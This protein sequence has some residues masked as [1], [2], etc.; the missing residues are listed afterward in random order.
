[1]RSS[2]KT[3]LSS[4]KHSPAHST[5]KCYNSTFFSNTMKGNTKFPETYLNPL[6]CPIHL[7]HMPKV[8]AP[9]PAPA[10]LSSDSLSVSLFSFQR[11]PLSS[12]VCTSV[13]LSPFP[14]SQDLLNY[15]LT[16]WYYTCLWFYTLKNPGLPWWRSGW[17]SACQCRGHG[18][19]PWSRKIPLA[20]EQLSLCAT[21]TEPAL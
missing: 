19:E 1:M 20:A 11:L 7:L 18:F 2:L 9:C 14:A 13:S 15:L 17:E 10:S 3:L 8:L 12:S 6:F 5:P 4:C 16:T 21:T